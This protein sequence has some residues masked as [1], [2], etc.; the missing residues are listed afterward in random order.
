MAEN[1]EITVLIADDHEVVREGLRLALLRSSHIRVV[2]E[3]PDGA[4]ALVEVFRLCP[5]V[6]LLDVQLPD[7]DGFQVAQRLAHAVPMPTTILISGREAA[8][9][10]GAVEIAGTGPSARRAAY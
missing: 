1:G 8:E 5:D 4:S 10:G 9:Y 6:V 3:A 7:I 2:G